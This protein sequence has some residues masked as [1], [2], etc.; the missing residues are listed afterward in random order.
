MNIG[1]LLVDPY[2]A[3]RRPNALVLMVAAATYGE[4]LPTTGYQLAIGDQLLIAGSL[5]TANRLRLTLNN[6]NVLFYV[7]HRTPSGSI[8]GWVWHKMRGE[9][10]VDQEAQSPT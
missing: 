5:R 8:G 2:D 1:H 9:A 6:P 7:P 4:I 10:L 3:S